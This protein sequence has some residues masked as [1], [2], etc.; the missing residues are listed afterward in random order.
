MLAGEPP[1][2]GDGCLREVL[3]AHVVAI[4]EP[5]SARRLDVPVPLAALI[6]RCL[7]KEP[8]DRPQSAREVYDALVSLSIASINISIVFVF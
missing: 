6:M 2:I 8:I 5:I 1:F 3:L 4:P 7:S